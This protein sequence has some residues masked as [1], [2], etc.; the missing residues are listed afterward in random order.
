MCK[1]SGEGFP[2]E[3]KRQIISGI[4]CCLHDGGLQ[5][6]GEPLLRVAGHL[7]ALLFYKLLRPVVHLESILI[8]L[9]NLLYFNVMISKN[10]IYKLLGAVVHVDPILIRL[11]YESSS[12]LMS[13]SISSLSAIVQI[14][15][16]AEL[17]FGQHVFTCDFRLFHF[18][19]TVF[20]KSKIWKAGLTFR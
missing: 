12:F 2:Q 7:E 6:L 8:H 9:A 18:Q 13:V 19:I 16:T 10:L 14:I 3:K 1:F 17:T 11:L 4:I 15:L 20:W 5:Q